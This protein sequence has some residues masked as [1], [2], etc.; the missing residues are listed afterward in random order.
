MLRVL[1]GKASERKIR[2]FEVACCRRIWQ[3]LPDGRSRQAIEVAESFADAQ[4]TEEELETAADAAW[5]VWDADRERASAEGKWDRGSP[6]LPYTPSAAAYNV[7][8][9][10]GWWGGAPAFVA[11]HEITR[12][13]TA[14]SGMEGAEQAVLLRDIFGN[15]FRPVAV[16]PSWLAWNGGIVVKLAQAVYDERAFDR[17]PMLADALE[18]AACHDAGILTHCRGP[19]PHVRGCWVVDLVLGKT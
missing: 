2:L 3:L 14:N 4:A 12:E 15:P 19:G 13:A 18:E 10:L 1:R 5:S 6:D 17:L 9:P 7:A 8:T 16:D 11:P